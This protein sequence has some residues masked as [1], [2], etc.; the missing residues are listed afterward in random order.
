MTKEIKKVRLS[1]HDLEAIIS[2]FQQHFL[3]NDRLWLF[4][5]RSDLNMKGGDIDLYVET[6]AEDADQAL[7]MKGNFLWDLEKKIGEQKIDVVIN[8]LNN[9]YP[10]PI[11]KIAKTKGVKIV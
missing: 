5:S 9:P 1:D 11:H 6:Y 4:G 7:H 2:L 3:P 10:L 8:I